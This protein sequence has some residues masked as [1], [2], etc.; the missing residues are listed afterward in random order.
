MPFLRPRRRPRKPTLA[1]ALKQ[2]AKAGVP[3]RR[4]RIEPDG[5]IALD[6]GEPQPTETD[7]PWLTELQK[8]TKQ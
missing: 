2:A 3:V 8:V 1:L 4:A 5:S 7:N 6:I